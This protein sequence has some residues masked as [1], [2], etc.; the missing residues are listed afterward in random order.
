MKT[1]ADNGLLLRRQVIA[2]S[3]NTADRRE[4]KEA[5]ELLFFFVIVRAEKTKN[6]SVNHTG[7]AAAGV[8]G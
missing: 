1:E 7:G 4:S 6:L 3:Q 8:G 5:S 2:W